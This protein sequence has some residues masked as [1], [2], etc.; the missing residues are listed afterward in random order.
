MFGTRGQFSRAWLRT[1]P[2]KGCGGGYTQSDMSH[3]SGTLFGVCWRVPDLIHM[4]K[5]NTCQIPHRPNP[6]TQSPL[7]DR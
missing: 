1:H 6:R 2:A 5:A 7:A 3:I 4:H